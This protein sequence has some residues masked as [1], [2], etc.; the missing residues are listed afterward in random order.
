M[1]T[2]IEDRPYTHFEKFKPGQFERERQCF[3]IILD[4]IPSSYAPTGVL[5]LFGGVG[6]FLSLVP[7]EWR[8]KNYHSWDHNPDCVSRVHGGYPEVTASVKDSFT[9]PFPSPLGIISADFNTFTI[10]KWATDPKYQNLIYGIFAAGADYVQITDS[11]VN[12][13]HLNGPH[14]EKFILPANRNK[15]I[16]TLDD[17]VEVF[18]DL[19]FLDHPYR[20]IKVAYHHGA[21]YLLFQRSGARK[22][23][24]RSI[25]V[26]KETLKGST[27]A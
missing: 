20:V 16:A 14:Y 25:N 24:V 2:D 5:E 27:N 17:Y 7:E 1:G 8:N 18:S 13:L 22:R 26:S 3:Q 6:L 21:S 12:R 10:L 4:A 11:A 9:S 15:R 23:K 19:V